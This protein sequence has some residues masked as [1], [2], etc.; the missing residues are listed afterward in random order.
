MKIRTKF[1]LFI[2]LPILL[3]Y[4]GVAVFN[5]MSKSFNTVFT[6]TPRDFLSA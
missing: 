4:I 2:V 1:I 3:I 6:T 5:T